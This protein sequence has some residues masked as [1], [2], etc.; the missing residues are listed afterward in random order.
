MKTYI[1]QLLT[2]LFFAASCSMPSLHSITEENHQILDDRI[3]GSW[4]HT[5]EERLISD[6]SINIKTDGNENV[7]SLKKDIVS[8]IDTQKT[9]SIGTEWNVDRGANITW[10]FGNGAEHG[11]DKITLYG[12]KESLETEIETLLSELNDVEMNLQ[13]DSSYVERLPYYLL[14]KQDPFAKL[15]ALDSYSSSET[16]MLG[17]INQF[18]QKTPPN[19][20]DLMAKQSL[21]DK[22]ESDIKIELT[23]IGDATFIN[24]SPQRIESIADR[25]GSEFSDNFIGG[26]TFAKLNFDNHMPIIQFF[27]YEY[28]EKLIKERRIRLKHETVLQT[29]TTGG[30]ESKI[31]LTAS[32]QELRTFLEKYVDND[33]F[34]D[35]PIELSMLAQ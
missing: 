4:V 11:L 1:Y 20:S 22:M 31:I 30:V 21:F 19:V 23:K 33:T 34:F 12:V 28:I 27:N 26:N 25:F 16:N 2:L 5:E 18:T 14:S 13:I 35:E 10:Y 3:E 7:D 17:L 15:N 32:T 6:F 24:F 29:S 9:V 8:N